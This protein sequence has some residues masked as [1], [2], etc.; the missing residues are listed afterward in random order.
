MVS[1]SNMAG[2]RQ[3]IA[4]G[5]MAINALQTAQG[6]KQKSGKIGKWVTIIWILLLTL[7]CDYL[8]S[9]HFGAVY[10]GRFSGPLLDKLHFEMTRAS[11][12][13]RYEYENALALPPMKWLY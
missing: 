13:T 4:C 12:R 5:T 11:A 2:Q 3:T 7:C 1:S 10:C 8:L 9:D 6:E